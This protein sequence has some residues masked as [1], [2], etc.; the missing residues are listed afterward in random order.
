MSVTMNHLLENNLLST[1][2]H[3][4]ITGLSTVTQLLKNF[5]KCAGVFAAGEVVDV[6]YL[7]FEKAFDTV[8]H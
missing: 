7:D 8:P 4:F 2:Q 5:D 3:G 1:K 6:I